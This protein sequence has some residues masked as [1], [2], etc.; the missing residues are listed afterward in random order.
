MVPGDTKITVT[1]KMV[2]IFGAKISTWNPYTRNGEG[3]RYREGR[4][5]GG[6]IP[7]MKKQR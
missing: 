1:S 7:Q 6:V 4:R 2:T 3:K 5:E